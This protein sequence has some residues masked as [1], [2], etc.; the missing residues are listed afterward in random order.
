MKSTIFHHSSPACHSR[1]F[2]RSVSFF[3]LSVDTEQTWLEAL[4]APGDF[5]TW[6]DQRDTSD[7]LNTLHTPQV[8]ELKKKRKC[9]SFIFKNTFIDNYAFN[10]I[11][12]RD[13]QN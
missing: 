11:D 12:I 2:G 3:F 8:S 5:Q 4:K 9:I 10:V 7:F 13:H 1:D 6:T